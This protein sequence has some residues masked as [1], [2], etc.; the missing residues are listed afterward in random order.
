MQNE[1]IAEMIAELA[2]IREPMN[3]LGCGMGKGIIL[4][5]D[6]D[7]D[8]RTVKTR[9]VQYLAA[10]EIK[11]NSKKEK[12][13][14]NYQMGVYKYDRCDNEKRVLDFLETQEFLPVVIVGG[15]IPENLIGR[16]Y[17][18]RCIW[19][20]Q[21]SLNV[22]KKYK[23][24]SDFVKRNK[25]EI[26]NLMS[27]IGKNEEMTDV[28]TILSYK[29]IGR[30]LVALVEI[31]KRIYEKS[32][33]AKTEITKNR[34]VFV[35]MISETLQI[36]DSYEWDYDI[37]DFVKECFIRQSKKGEIGI[38][39]LNENK[40]EGT[41]VNRILYDDDYY[42]VTD[43]VLRKICESYLQMVSLVQ[44]KNEMYIS[45]M[46]EC[47]KGKDK[48]FTKKKVIWNPYGWSE[49]IRFICIKKE[50]LMA[51]DGMLLEDMWGNKNA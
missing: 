27:E 48:C 41:V 10:V 31:R 38:S 47:D 29:E 36:M 51:S 6:D 13:P 50:V 2:F 28:E 11:F 45:G 30:I 8:A 49:R 4:I 12:Q 3:Y 5:A 15:L 40:V 18:F 1:W 20:E 35:K 43:S 24:F 9:L 33:M 26:L 25:D 46:L 22:E 16:G 7:D 21:N 44:L 17:A 34:E 37:S 32:G 19:S 14:C 23:L 42:Y 39:I